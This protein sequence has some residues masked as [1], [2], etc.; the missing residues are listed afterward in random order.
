MSSPLRRDHGLVVASTVVIL[1]SSALGGCHSG[2]SASPASELATTTPAATVTPTTAPTTGASTPATTAAA[3]EN[4]VFPLTPGLQTVRQGLVT[5]G[6][7]RLPHRRVYTITDVVKVVDGVHAVIALDQDFD[8]GEL[9]EQSLEILALD[10]AHDLLYLGSYTE[11]YEGGQ[12]VNATDAWLAGVKGGRSG[13]L[14][15]GSPRTGT[16]A[17]RQALVP[18]EGEATAKVVRTDAKKCVKFRCFTDV[19]VIEE[20]GSE[21]K[22]YAPGVGGILTEPLSGDAQETEELINVTSLSQKGLAEISAEVI[23]VDQ[24]ARKVASDVYGKSDPARRA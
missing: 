15:P 16:P 23:K 3:R 17:F 5:K 21:L 22:Y 20:G 4:P 24:Q 11:A 14:V 6:S 8:G 12:F 10:R 7:R 9:S 2:K 13:I 18:G 1:T 19:V